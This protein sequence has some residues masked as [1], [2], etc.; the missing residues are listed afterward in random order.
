MSAVAQI[1]RS[2]GYQISGCDLSLDTPYI[3]K[4]RKPG[5]KL[6]SG[7]SPAH[8]D[9]A[10]ILAVTPAVF[11]QNDDHPETA[12]GK[13]KGILTKWQDFMGKYLHRDKYV[14]CV[15]GTHGKSTTTAMAGLLLE[16][17]GL[18]PT[19]EVGSHGKRL[20]EQCPYRKIRVFHLRSR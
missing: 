10:D 16:K 17:A 5:I 6:Y 8:L 19:V 4:V 20:A 13:E 9:N 14:I 18:D 2:Q 7:H 1:A 12:L 11:Y 3:E 15:A